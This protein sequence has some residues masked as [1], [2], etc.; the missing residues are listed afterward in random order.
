[1]VLL[2]TW[3]SRLILFPVSA[4]ES[5]IC[6]RA[7]WRQWCSPGCGTWLSLTYAVACAS[8]IHHELDFPS[9]LSSNLCSPLKTH[10]LWLIKNTT[11]VH[12]RC[13]SPPIPQEIWHWSRSVSFRN[14]AWKLLAFIFRDHLKP[15]QGTHTGTHCHVTTH[16]VYELWYSI[17]K[18]RKESCSFWL[19]LSCLQQCCQHLD[20]S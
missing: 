10:K 7:T 12:C 18:S 4:E 2:V 19:C 20:F 9:C 3:G 14:A 6:P 16:N 17:C 13:V 11:S 8:A 5:R 15:R 1:M